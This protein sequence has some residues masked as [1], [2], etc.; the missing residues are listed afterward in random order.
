MYV[1][2]STGP[3]AVVLDCPTRTGKNKGDEVATVIRVEGTRDVE[4][5]TGQ[6]WAKMVEFAK[7]WSHL[8][9]LESESLL[10]SLVLFNLGFGFSGCY[11]NMRYI[12]WVM[13]AE[14]MA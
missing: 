5:Q 9:C 4:S 6:V 12:P 8:F 3:R 11:R 2:I 14:H 1:S 10:H 7:L 13:S